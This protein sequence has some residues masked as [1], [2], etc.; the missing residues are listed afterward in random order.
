MKKFFYSVLAAATM[1]LATTSCSQEEEMLGGGTVDNGT[2]QKVTFTVQ[3]PGDDAASR[4]IAEGVEVGKGNMADKL[5]W[6]LY[7]KGETE[8]L[9]HGDG[10]QNGTDENGNKIFKASIDMVKGLEYNVLFFA[11]NEEGVA[12][13]MNTVAS[14]TDLTKLTL[15]SELKANQ[16]GYDA[17]MKCHTHKVNAEAVTTVTLTRP[18]AQINAATSLEDLQ[19]ADKLKALVETSKLIIYNVP[20]QFDILTGKATVQ[21]NVPFVT[22]DEADILKKIATDTYKNELIEV[23]GETYYYLNM[24]YVLAGEEA[25]SD[26][27]THKATFSFYRPA[28]PQLVN[29]FTIEHLPIQRNYRTNVIGN[30]LTQSEEFRIVI[31]AKFDTPDK[32]IVSREYLETAFAQG[33]KVELFSDVTFEDGESLVIPE[34]VTVELELNGYTFNNP[35]EGAAAI[36]NKGTLII[37]GN[38]SIN[39]GKQ[40]L[41]VDGC[42]VIENHGSLTIEGGNYGTDGKSARAIYNVGGDVVINAGT[43]ASID[44]YKNIQNGKTYNAYVFVTEGG[45]ITINDATVEC[46]PKGI[47]TCSNNGTIT[48]NGGKYIMTGAPEG[49]TDS[50]L[51]S[52]QWSYYMVYLRPIADDKSDTNN[53]V[54]LNGGTFEWIQSRPDRANTAIYGDGIVSDAWNTAGKTEPVSGTVVISEK[55]EIN[56]SGNQ[57]TQVIDTQAEFET[58]LQAGGTILLGKKSVDGRAADA[59]YVWKNTSKDVE[60]VGSEEGVSIS[61]G[62]GALNGSDG[63]KNLS[64]NNI[65]LKFPSSNPDYTGFHHTTSETYTNCIIENQFFLYA[66]TASFNGCTFKQANADKYNV[67]TYGAATV[68]FDNCTFES[69]GKSVLVY[70][71]ALDEEFTVTLNNCVLNASSPVD[72]KAAIEIDS[73]F[74]NGGNGSYVVNINNTTATGFATGTISNNT[75]FNQKK[76][77]KATIYVDGVRIIA[78]GVTMNEAGEYLINSAAGLKWIANVVNSTTPYT[79]T[80]FDNAIVKLTNNI[81]LKNEEWIPIGDDRSQ[82]TEFHGTFDG[83]GYTVSNVKITKKTDIDDADKSSYGLF[84]NVKGTVKNLTVENVSISNVPKFVGALIGRLNDGLVEN[85]HVKNSSVIIENWTIGGLVGQFNKGKISGC[86]VE[87][88]TITGYAAVG[89]IAGI[90][91][92]EG[93]RTIENC[94]VRDCA[95]VQNGTFGGDYD[96]MF[97]IIVGALYSGKL[98][99][100]INNS[101][102]EN[103]TAKGSDSDLLCGYI[104]EG[105]KLYIDG[106]EVIAD[107][108]L[109]KDNEYLISTVNG[110]K[111]LAT[112]TNGGNTFANKTVKLTANLD[113]NN[114]EWTPI[115]TSDG[116]KGTF[117]GNNHIVSNL[118]ITGNNSTVG[119]FANTSEGEIKNL[120]VNNAKVSGRLNVGVVAGNPYTS[121]YTNI[122]VTGH[123]EVNGMSYVGGVGGKNAYAN[124]KDITI[125]VDATSYVKAN[126]IENGTAF[127]SYVGGACGFNGEGGHSFT[128]VTSNIDVTG[129]TC[130]VGGLF[131]IAHY[132]NSFINCSSSGD[133]T[134]TDAAE[135]AVAEEIGG[136]AGVW[137]NQNGTTV[138]FEGCK[139]TGTLKTN[140]TEGVDLSDNK[141]TGKAYSATGTGELIIK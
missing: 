80:I 1:L 89:A 9:A 127:R 17:F 141:I 140:I 129:T 11:Y 72:G 62:S 29:E 73:S 134:I 120:T 88:T 41:G 131:G 79:P 70:K 32:V 51:N 74:P 3:L 54:Y 15:K 6:A 91:L 105:D 35:V 13:Q 96:E 101:L 122:K 52:Y 104:A 71:E 24:A 109:Y 83:Q 107:G 125:D 18:F 95:L 115:G 48:V 114:E 12:F 128:N 47:F 31:D 81:D 21:E 103:T 133:V 112:T 106:Y 45:S 30:L 43:F 113:L 67:W 97:G 138:T 42:D 102:V 139:F 16:E 39:N 8:R 44:S 94:T 100:N 58:A 111:W 23:E 66:A 56:W 25:N 137:H 64:F 108:V 55:A 124:W 2:T 40:A 121:K 10:V 76:G 65:V 135:A 60:I 36:I 132:G 22:Y 117:D 49:T 84:G 33:G 68:T 53:T 85:C 126:S 59:D 63:A 99:V 123:V 26:E 87:G 118:L 5:I 93:E 119:L 86:S 77:T 14:E 37:K 28:A 98:T 46:N 78:D 38:G 27:S 110:L 90:V 57:V 75:L 116:F 61:F 19:K 82:R 50:D 20:T 4:A 136:I 130:D 92:N 69:A 7:E 34:G